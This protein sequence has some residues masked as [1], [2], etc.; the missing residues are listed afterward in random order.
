MP[1][2]RSSEL[3]LLPFRYYLRILRGIL[4]LGVGGFAFA[5]VGLSVR[6]FSQT[7]E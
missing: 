5:L 4:L 1:V 3:V 2:V 6:R 7:I